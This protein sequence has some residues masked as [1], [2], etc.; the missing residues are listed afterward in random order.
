MR[1]RPAFT[2][3]ATTAAAALVAAACS[4]D[5]QAASGGDGDSGDVA[6][7]VTFWTYPIGIADSVG[8]WEPHVEDFQQEYPDVEVEVVMQ[9]FSNRE[10][11][12]VTAITG[13]N[14]PDVVYF[15]PDFIPQY[16]EEGILLPLD[17]LRDDW[18]DFY[19]SALDAN[20]WEDTL[21]GA[22]LLMQMQTSYCNTEAMAAAGVQTCPTTWDELREAAPKFVDAGYYATEYSGVSTLN[23]NFY[24]YLWQA[25]G[26]V[27]SE[28]LQSAAFNSP[29]GL[30]ALEFIKEMVDNGWVPEQPLSVTEPFEQTAVGKAQVGY[31]PGAQLISTRE[32][33]DP[34]I[35]QTAPPMTHK[36]QVASG[37][38]GAWSIFNTTDA[39]EAA[40]AWVR[41]LSDEEFIRTFNGETGYL[42]PRESIDDLFQDDPQIA[43][44]MEYLDKVRVG[45]M[46]P[47]A[48]QIIDAI[49][50]HIQAVLLEGVDPQTA[51]DAAEQDVNDLLARG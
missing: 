2:L 48:R 12:L 37:S 32:I 50:P 15:N 18:D 43:E 46:H 11:A 14:A 30:E 41:Y 29:E 24:V 51:L 34:A 21:Y 39:P 33:V 17:D 42:P 27:L 40:Q 4:N 47:Q 49:R 5:T 13:N 7:T 31:V 28:D 36:E 35:I 8:W 26:E 6:G 25:G 22:P 10:E 9:A 19:D 3:I 23:H 16:A 38:V 20:R 45:V 1:R 44:G